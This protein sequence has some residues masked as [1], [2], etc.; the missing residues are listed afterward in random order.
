MSDGLPCRS[1]KHVVE[2]EISP[3]TTTDF[4]AGFS[5]GKNQCMGPTPIL[6]YGVSDQETGQKLCNMYHHVAFEW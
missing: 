1:C 4:C 2:G 5:C 3:A 6:M